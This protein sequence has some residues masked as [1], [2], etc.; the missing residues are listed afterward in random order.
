[1][2][3]QEHARADA[4]GR[5]C[6][7]PRRTPDRCR[8]SGASCRRGRAGSRARRGRRRTRRGS[9]RVEAWPSRGRRRRCRGPRA[10]R[11]R[12]RCP[13]R[14]RDR[15]AGGGRGCRQ[16]LSAATPQPLSRTPRRSRGAAVTLSANHELP[17]CSAHTAIERA[18]SSGSA[19]TSAPPRRATSWGG[20]TRG[21]SPGAGD[22]ISPTTTKAAVP[23]AVRAPASGMGELDEEGVLTLGE[24]DCDL[25]VHRRAS[26]SDTQ[27]IGAVARQLLDATSLSNAAFGERGARLRVEQG[28]SQPRCFDVG[29]GCECLLRPRR[30]GSALSRC[31]TA[32]R[33]ARHARAMRGGHAPHRGRRHTHATRRSRCP[34]PRRADAAA[35]ALLTNKT[36]SVIAGDVAAQVSASTGASPTAM[37]RQA[38]T[39]CSHEVTGRLHCSSRLAPGSP[40][41]RRRRRRCCR[42]PPRGDRRSPPPRRSCAPRTPRSLRWRM[43]SGRDA[44][45]LMAPC[46]TRTPA[47]ATRDATSTRADARLDEHDRPPAVPAKADASPALPATTAQ[48]PSGSNAASHRARCSAARPASSPAWV[49]SSFGS[50]VGDIGSRLRGV[51][52]SLVDGSE[53]SRIGRELDERSA[54]QLAKLGG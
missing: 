20:R 28:A 30:G 54:D 8:G 42:L 38:R 7:R 32:S 51:V 6:R 47:A 13:T 17:G 23:P 12:H 15:G 11:R 29:H 1:M 36:V 18:R 25:S 44:I 24:D 26:R 2:H 46:T 39:C 4:A 27:R 10:G 19:S 21:T 43:S 22:G 41:R 45:S 48:G 37:H 52:R 34:R 53:R 5:A 40:W 49:G 33:S 16:R 50:S 35:D 9:T 31:G 3:R 14:G